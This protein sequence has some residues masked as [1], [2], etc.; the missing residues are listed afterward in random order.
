VGEEFVTRYKPPGSPLHQ[1]SH[2]FRCGAIA[3]GPGDFEA[4]MQTAEKKTQPGFAVHASSLL[5]KPVPVLRVQTSSSARIRGVTP[6]YLSVLKKRDRSHRQPCFRA[7]ARFSQFHWGGGTP[8]YLSPETD[9]RFIPL[10]AGNAST[11]R[12]TRKIGIES[13]ST[14]NFRAPHMEIV[15]KMGFN[16]LSMGR[17][18]I[19]RK[20]CS[21]PSTE[22][23]RT[24]RPAT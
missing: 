23:N 16:R 15:R 7:I 4:A 13:R 20:K 3:Y 18:R 10:Y 22:S 6:P 12:R 8:T 14:R 2:G 21:R 5:R 24:N 9:R 19:S 11:L 1:L 17:F